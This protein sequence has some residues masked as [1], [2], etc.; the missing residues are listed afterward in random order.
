MSSQAVGPSRS[1]SLRSAGRSRHWARVAEAEALGRGAHLERLGAQPGREARGAVDDDEAVAGAGGIHGL[2]GLV[3]G[4][5]RDVGA[6]RGS[7]RHR[8]IVPA[9]HGA[10]PA[11]DVLAAG[12]QQQARRGR[13]GHRPERDRRALGA[14]G[15]RHDGPTAERVEGVERIAREG[16]GGRQV[17]VCLAAIA[18]RR[19][20]PA[21]V[22]RQAHP[23]GDLVIDR[24]A[25]PRGRA[26]HVC[27]AER[28]RP[29]AP[30]RV[31][32]H[33]EAQARAE[34][35]LEAERAAIEPD[36]H[37]GR[38]FPVAMPGACQG[39]SRCQPRGRARLLAGGTGD[40]GG[41]GGE[42]ATLRGTETGT[43]TRTRTRTRANRGARRQRMRVTGRP[44]SSARC[45][46]LL[47]AP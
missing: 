6:E 11:R 35:P 2:V 13:R 42:V 25:Q 5:Q 1:R 23:G 8:S 26:Q 43:G 19:R 15:R 33:R 39:S 14:G 3:E 41:G 10:L 21:P 30:G 9:A 46:R 45:S 44:S 37:E 17:P 40:R 38:H 4:E 27:V 47:R 7:C 32:P 36:A 24:E 28:G 20:A 29:E 12:A 16:A 34:R 18:A 31:V 22:E